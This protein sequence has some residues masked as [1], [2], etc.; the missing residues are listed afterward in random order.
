MSDWLLSGLAV[1]AFAAVAALGQRAGFAL[2]RRSV[3]SGGGLGSEVKE[4]SDEDFEGV[5]R[6]I[7]HLL[8]EH[9]SKGRSER[10]LLVIVDRDEAGLSVTAMRDPLA[11][12]DEFVKDPYRAFKLR[13]AEG[14]SERTEGRRA[15]DESSQGEAD[16]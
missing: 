6:A 4:L 2:A 12:F 15:E 9:D 3:R 1:V 11:E 16:S 14:A 5:G 13:E 7:Y 8:E 10:Q